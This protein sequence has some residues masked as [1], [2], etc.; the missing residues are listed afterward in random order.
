MINLVGVH[1]L[2]SWTVIA[3]LFGGRSGKQCKERW[4]NHLQPHIKKEAWSKEEDEILIQAHKELGNEWLKLPNDSMGEPKTPSRTI[5]TP[6][7]VVNFLQ[8]AG[9][10]DKHHTMLLQM[11]ESPS[12]TISLP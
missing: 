11:E 6:P 4:H 8:S 7:N 9:T 1:E 12:R 2:K 3:N 5:G 10:T